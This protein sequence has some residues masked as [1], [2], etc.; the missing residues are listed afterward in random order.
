MADIEI[1]TNDGGTTTVS[2][3]HIEALQQRLAHPLV[4]P[5][6]G[7]YDDVRQLWN[8]MHDKRPGL[9]IRC[10]GVADVQAGV[11]FARENKLLVAVRGGGHN[12][13]GSGSCDGGLLIDLS[14][15]RAVHVDSRAQTAR[16]QGGATLGDVDRETQVFGL[17]VPGGNVSTTGVAGLTLGGGMGNLRRKHGLAI[18]NLLSVDIVTADGRAR[19]ASAEENPEL[20]WGVRGGGGNFGV[21]TSFEFRAHPLGPEVALCM[22]LYAVDESNAADL[23]RAWYAFMET[24]PDEISSLGVFWSVPRVEGFPEEHQGRRVFIPQS[25]YCGDAEEGMRAMQPLRELGMPILDLSGVMPWTAMQAALDPFVPKGERQYYF[26]SSY[27]KAMDGATIDALAPRAV[28]PPAEPV[29]IVLWHQG[30]A[31]HR[32]GPTDTAFPNRHDPILFSVDCIWD[33]PAQNDEVIAWARAYLR[34]MAPHS[35][36]GHYVNFSGLGEEGQ[37]LVKRAYGDNHE[38]LVALKNDVDPTNLFRLNQN[39]RPTV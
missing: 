30:G 10:S 35:P 39:I 38:R 16:V 21:V 27:L 19:T 3:E 22:P 20:F 5:Q 8:G 14:L 31:M 36:G 34:D 28:A 17:A 9:I 11:D 37:E 25:I 33:D 18:D 32:V 6:A 4:T 12:V 29:L 1:V 23:V 13:S 2:A 7:D 24:A 15:M 26:K